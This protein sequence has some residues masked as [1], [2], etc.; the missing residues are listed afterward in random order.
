M[1]D[2][3]LSIYDR[4]LDYARRLIAD[5]PE[6][7]CCIQP[8][9]NMNH[10]LWVLGHLAFVADKVTGQMVLGLERRT[11]ASWDPLFDNKSKPVADP[12]NYPPK[13][14]L[15]RALSD[16][17]AR[18]AAALRQ[19]DASLLSRPMPHEGF[20]RRFPTVAQ[21]L[22]HTMIGHEQMHLGQLSAWRRAQ[23]LPPV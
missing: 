12:A 18:V 16:G 4:N 3:L 14:E 17:H 20:A 13:E 23:G 11:P 1:I 7:Q 8:A 6:D 21:G 10:A 5:L 9:A 19:A 22:I 15:F 2:D